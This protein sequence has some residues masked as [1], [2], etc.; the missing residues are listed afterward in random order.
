MAELSPLAG[1][2]G[3]ELRWP[4]VAGPGVELRWPPVAGP[5]LRIAEIPLLTQ[6]NL[7]LP[8]PGPADAPDAAG[9]Q[10]GAPLPPPGGTAVAGE[11]TV[12]GLGPDEWLVLAPPRSPVRAR[13]RVALG[14]QHCSIVDV[15]A[16]RTTIAIEGEQAADVL[17]HGCALDLHPTRFPPGSVA[18]TAIAGTDVVLLARPGGGFWLLVRAS[19]ARHLAGWLADACVEY[20]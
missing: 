11:L 4:T 1:W 5:G 19:T 8:A 10:L 9:A 16:A 18:Q 12:A 20:R 17:A 14:G 6:V 7:R 3:V 13:L 2:P 15:S